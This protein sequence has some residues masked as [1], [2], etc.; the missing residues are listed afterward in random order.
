M[1]DGLKISQRGAIAWAKA[2][3]PSSVWRKKQPP[4][5][6]GRYV[7]GQHG[8]R[9]RGL[10]IVP[11]GRQRIALHD[12]VPVSQWEGPVLTV[13]EAAERYERDGTDPWLGVG[14]IRFR[15]ERGSWVIGEVRVIEVADEL[16]PQRV[17]HGSPPPGMG[18]AG[19]G[20]DNDTTTDAGDTE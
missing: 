14:P 3:V 11:A 19:A 7:R 13:A 1:A 15:G 12:L 8:I 6:P 20:H 2:L 18:Q 4:Y 10:V 17:T 9:P 16:I 5:W